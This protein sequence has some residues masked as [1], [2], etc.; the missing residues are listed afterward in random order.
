[1]VL[2]DE[3]RSRG[4]KSFW[5]PTGCP[6]QARAHSAPVRWVLLRAGRWAH[7]MALG[8][9][10]QAAGCD[11]V[12]TGG[13]GED[14]QN[15]M[16][17]QM[18]RIPVF[19]AAGSVSL[20]ELAAIFS[21]ADLVVTNSTGPL[22]WRSPWEFLRCQSITIPTCHPTR[23]GPYPAYAEGRDE[24]QVKIAPLVGIREGSGGHGRGHCGRRF[25]LMPKGACAQDGQSWGSGA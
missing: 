5:N 13:P 10:L 3:E 7:F 21:C 20:R 19:I 6:L 12:V 2:S 8:N 16:I 1:M 24:H 18:H 14:Y 11:V 9:Q 22:H 4:Q 25:W 15:I 17:D 23:W